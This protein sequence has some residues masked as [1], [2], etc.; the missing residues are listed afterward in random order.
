MMNKLKLQVLHN[1]YGF[2]SLLSQDDEIPLTEEMESFSA[3]RLVSII[4]SIPAISN[5]PFQ[6]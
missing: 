4:P 2:I 6:C 3:F 5:S 1:T